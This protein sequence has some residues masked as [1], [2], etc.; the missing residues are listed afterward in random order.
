MRSGRGD[1]GN[2]S[3]S[4]TFRVANIRGLHARA[5]SK[6]VR[7]ATQFNA[8]ITVAKDGQTVDGTSIMGLLML[9]AAKGS[10]IEVSAR[11]PEAGPALDALSQLIARRFDEE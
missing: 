10:E 5:A 4:R 8:E 11:G 2:K 6:F 7:C 9:A 1:M 3:E